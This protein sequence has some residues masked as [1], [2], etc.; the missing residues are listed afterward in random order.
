[1]QHSSTRVFRKECLNRVLP[2]YDNVVQ[3]R[4]VSVRWLFRVKHRIEIKIVVFVG[5]FFWKRKSTLIPSFTVTFVV[6]QQY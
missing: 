1:V 6:P 2:E 5:W 3:Y 4:V